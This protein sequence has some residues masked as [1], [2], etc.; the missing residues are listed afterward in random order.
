MITMI[1]ILIRTVGELAAPLVTEV[2]VSREPTS[3]LSRR[4]VYVNDR[5]PSHFFQCSVADPLTD[6][7]GQPANQT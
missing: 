1:L 2:L 6:S 4:I 5:N 3:L 7:S